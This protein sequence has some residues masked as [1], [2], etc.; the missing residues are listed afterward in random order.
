MPPRLSRWFGPPCSASDARGVAQSFA[1]CVSIR[2][3]LASG[4]PAASSFADGVSH[5]NDDDAFALMAR[6]D[7]CRREQSSL[8]L[9]TKLVKV[10]EYALRASDFV[11]PR[12]EHASDVFNDD[13]PR[14]RLDDDAA[15]G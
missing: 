12:R 13:K 1:W 4:C 15:S 8:S 10:S 6:A 14:A 5:R 7:L 3:I 9:E 2:C 11:R